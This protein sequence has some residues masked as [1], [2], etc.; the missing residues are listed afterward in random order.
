[1]KASKNCIR[2]TIIASVVSLTLTVH[3]MAQQEI[4]PDRFESTAQGIQRS[5]GS[6]KTHDS[7]AAMHKKAN[8]QTAKVA[9]GRQA[10]KQIASL[11]N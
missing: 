4:S 3:L 7:R 9:N 2:R 6:Q 5:A 8:K 10:P 11:K 1:M